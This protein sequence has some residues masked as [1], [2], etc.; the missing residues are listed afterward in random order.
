VLRELNLRFVIIMLGLAFIVVATTASLIISKQSNNEYINPGSMLSP[1]TQSDWFKTGKKDA[2][3]PT[4]SEAVGRA[5]YPFLLRVKGEQLMVPERIFVQPQALKPD[6]RIVEGFS[7]RYDDRIQ[8]MVDPVSQEL[9]IQSLLDQ[10]ISPNTKGETKVYFKTK[11]RNVDAVAREA[12]AQKWQSGLENR[13]PSTI[14]WVEK[15][16]G[17]VPY[18]LYTL[19]GDI[20]VAELKK[21]A[22]SLVRV[23]KG[24]INLNN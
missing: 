16:E 21:I 10:E 9:D 2:E 22:A 7:F 3:N 14:Q 18:L 13:Y 12:G 8:L 5:R 4:V 15:G 1:A 17:D 6:G 20:S 24:K 23:E 11:V 19:A